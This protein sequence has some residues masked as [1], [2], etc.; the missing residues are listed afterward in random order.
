MHVDIPLTLSSMMVLQKYLYVCNITELP[1][2]I[3][4]FFLLL[5]KVNC[6]IFN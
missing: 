4:L 3:H 6:N 5:K 2:G 1:T